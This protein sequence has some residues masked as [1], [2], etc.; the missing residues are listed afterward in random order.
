MSEE[1]I[2]NC[3]KK[4]IEKNPKFCVTPGQLKIGLALEICYFE[5]FQFTNTFKINEM[6]LTGKQRRKYMKETFF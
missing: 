1:K 2:K 6:I 4:K 3:K 5:S